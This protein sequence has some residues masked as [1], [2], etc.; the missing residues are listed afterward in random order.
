MGATDS[1]TMEEQ[2][3][4]ESQ[5]DEREVEGNTEGE[6]EE[7][8]VATD[9]GREEDVREEEQ[10][11]SRGKEEMGWVRGTGEE[12]TILQSETPELLTTLSLSS[13]CGVLVV[14]TPG[15]GDGTRGCNNLGGS[16]NKEK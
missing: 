14:G 3:W 2:W 10:G 5:E 11:G 4:L 8:N 1:S 16:G 9:R 6:Q 15:E 12:K 7:T 13:R